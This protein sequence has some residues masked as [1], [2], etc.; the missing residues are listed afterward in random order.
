MHCSLRSVLRTVN[1]AVLCTLTSQVSGCFLRTVFFAMHVTLTSEI[2][3]WAL[4]I[5]LTKC[6]LRKGFYACILKKWV[7]L[8]YCGLRSGPHVEM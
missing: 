3:G 1:C 8:T 4:R 6:S 2:I 7:L 5:F